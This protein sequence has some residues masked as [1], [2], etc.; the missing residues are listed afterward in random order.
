MHKSLHYGLAPRRK[1]P[2]AKAAGETLDPSKADPLYLACLAIKQEN[3]AIGQYLLHL[4]DLA[5][6][7]F[8]IAQYTAMTG[9]RLV[10]SLNSFTS[11]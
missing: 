7:E 4:F 6:L 3:A 10:S 11:T 9:I 1:Q 8:V 2:F 5:G